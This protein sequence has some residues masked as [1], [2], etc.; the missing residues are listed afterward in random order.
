MELANED[1]LTRRKFLQFSAGTAAAMM[2]TALPNFSWAQALKTEKMGLEQCL[3]LTP[4]QMAERSNLVQSAYRYITE[5]CREIRT[6]ALRDQVLQVIDNPA[7]T[8][9]ERYTTSDARKILW[10]KLVAANYLSDTTTVTNYDRS[11]IK[12]QKI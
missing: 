6:A 8:F 9:M 5:I 2:V 12:W 1:G 4:L 10:Q 11:G 7:P 3:D